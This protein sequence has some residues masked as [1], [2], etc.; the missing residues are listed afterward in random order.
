MTRIPAGDNWV[1][2]IKFDGFRMH[3]RIVSGAAALLT[4]NGLGWT[5]KYPKVAAPISTLNCRQAYVD[6]ELCAVLP[7]GTTSFSALQGLGD[8]PAE[9]VYFTTPPPHAPRGQPHIQGRLLSVSG[10]SM[11]R[12]LT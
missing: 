6:G 2:E 5:A 1:H 9:L 8:A 11:G 7:D 3:A 4:R 12:V 10:T